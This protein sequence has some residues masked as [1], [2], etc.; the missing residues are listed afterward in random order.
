MMRSIRTHSQISRRYFLNNCPRVN[1]SF[2]CEA[3]K[4]VALRGERLHKLDATSMQVL[5][6]RPTTVDIRLLQWSLR[7]RFKEHALHVSLLHG[8]L[9]LIVRR[10]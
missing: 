1:C 9:R 8:F 3:K 5:Y 4:Y 10:R 2:G 7:R 6:V